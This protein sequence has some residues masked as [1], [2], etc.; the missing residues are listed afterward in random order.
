MTMADVKNILLVGV[1]G[2]D[3]ILVGKIL[4]SGL[5]E[6]GYDA[7]HGPAGR[8]RQQSGE[9]RQ[10]SVLADLR[11]GPGGY[12]GFLRNYRSSPVA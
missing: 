2:Q 5:I 3:T 9:I 6:D 7:R 1:G 12:S 10:K 8:Q 11:Q 4:S